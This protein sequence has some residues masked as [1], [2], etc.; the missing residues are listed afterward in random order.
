MRKKAEDDILQVQ[1]DIRDN[2][3]KNLEAAQKAV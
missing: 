3:K 2:L 1:K